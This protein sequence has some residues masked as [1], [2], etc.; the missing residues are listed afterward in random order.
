MLSYPSA[1]VHL[2]ERGTADGGGEKGGGQ[3]LY[4]SHPRGLENSKYALGGGGEEVLITSVSEYQNLTL[5][6]LHVDLK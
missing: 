2:T 1:R 4:Y 6:K 3:R 5:A